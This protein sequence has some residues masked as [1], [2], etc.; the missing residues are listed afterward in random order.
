MAASRLHLPLG[1]RS[2]DRLPAALEPDGYCILRQLIPIDVVD[3]A[4]RRLTLEIVRHGVTAEQIQE[5]AQATFFPHL[6]WE[7]PIL[8][9]RS[10]IDEAVDRRPDEEWGDAQLLMRFPDEATSWPLEPHT[11]SLPHWAGDR[12][13]RVI[14][15]AALTKARHKDGALAVWP[16]SHR[17]ESSGARLLEFDAGD[18]ILM[19]PKLGH[20]GT[21]NR[22]GTIRYAVYFRL[23]TAAA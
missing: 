19:H 4:L 10:C 22:G 20:S 13:Y 23:L 12:T 6:R 18:V 14:A 17:G 9:V 2:A 3:A 8:A 1:A 7:E 21:L 11:D 5:W 15:G 16:G